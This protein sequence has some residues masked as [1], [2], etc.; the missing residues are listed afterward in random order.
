MKKRLLTALGKRCLNFFWP[1][2]SYG[3][4]GEVSLGRISYFW[5]SLRGRGECLG[6]N[7]TGQSR[8]CQQCLSLV[9]QQTLLLWCACLLTICKMLFHNRG[10]WSLPEVET[11]CYKG[12]QCCFYF[13]F[14]FQL[15]WNGRRNYSELCK[16]IICFTFIAWQPSDKFGV[17]SSD[18]KMSWELHCCGLRISFLINL[19]A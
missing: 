12:K 6:T 4:A 7:R 5:K 1:M 15:V 17:W 16:K 18:S 19:A 3:F 13:I 9:W 11:E 10:K 2:F 14:F 8:K